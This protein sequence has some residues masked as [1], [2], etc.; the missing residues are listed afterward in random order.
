MI[1]IVPD[2]V[3]DAINRALDSALEGQPEETHQ[4]RPHLYNQLLDY[5][6]EHGEIPKF[7]IVKKG[8]NAAD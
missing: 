8:A 1:A 4:C 6:N 5:Y 7:N 3:D 2:F